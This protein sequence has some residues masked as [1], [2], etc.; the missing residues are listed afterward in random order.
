MKTTKARTRA[1][2]ASTWRLTVASRYG[3]L[4]LLVLLVVAFSL[5]IPDL[6]PTYVNIRTILSTQ[7][8][9]AIVAIAM[10]IP[11]VVGEFDLSAASNL[12][13]SAILV[14]G[15]ISKSGLGIEVAIIVAIGASTLIG[16]TTGLLVTRLGINSLITSLGMITVISG[17]VLAYTK[18]MPIYENIPQSFREISQ[19]TIGGMP[20]PVFYMAFIALFVWYVL[21]QTPIGRRMYAVGGSKVAARLAGINTKQL[22]LLA[23][24]ACGFLAGIAGVLT[25]ARIGSGNPTVGPGYMLPAFAACFLGASAIKPGTFNVLGTV[26]AIFTIAVGVT[27]L[28]LLGVPVWVEPLFNGVALIGA[29]ALTRYLRRE[30]V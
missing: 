2:R 5:A 1:E 30:P 3:L 17:V 22:T 20:L 4:G 25:A 15:L 29:V 21:E 10:I 12:G 13:L 24:V 11:L 26:L 28:E 14:T 18:G 6:F 7:S 16:L 8:V 19:F 9:L 27:G 23:F